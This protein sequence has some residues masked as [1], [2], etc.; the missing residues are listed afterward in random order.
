M[1]KTYTKKNGEVIN[2][3]HKKYNKDFYEKNKNKIN[4]DTYTCVY[5]KKDNIKTR[6]RYNHNKTLKH[7]LYEAL[8]KI[9]EPVKEN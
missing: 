5:C 4:E 2:Y 3:D 8:S 9:P 7:K 1:V 6:N